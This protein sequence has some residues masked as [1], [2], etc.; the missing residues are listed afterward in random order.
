MK[1][2]PYVTLDP[3]VLRGVPC[4]TGTHIPLATT[5]DSLA[6]GVS[7]KTLLMAHPMLRVE[8]IQ[9]AFAYAAELA[10]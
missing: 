7:V 6:A 10:S 1:K 3:N 4:H 5:F 2:R 9:A 8:A